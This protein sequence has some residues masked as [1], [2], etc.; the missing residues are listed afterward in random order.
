MKSN[1][2]RQGRTARITVAVVV[3][4]AMVMST[5]LSGAAF[6]TGPDLGKTL[7]NPTEVY[8]KDYPADVDAS[9]QAL[10]D[11]SVG[12]APTGEEAVTQSGDAQANGY[13]TFPSFNPGPTLAASDAANAAQLSTTHAGS[14]ITVNFAGKNQ[15]Q[16]FATCDLVDSDTV[17]GNPANTPSLGAIAYIPTDY[18]DSF[19]HTQGYYSYYNY[20]SPYTN[21]YTFDGPPFSYT[22]SFTKAGPLWVKIYYQKWTVKANMIT[23]GAI[24]IVDPAQ[25]RKWE[26]DMTTR[27]FK[28]FNYDLLGV[29]NYYEYERGKTFKTAWV[30]SGTVYPKVTP[31]RSGFKFGGWYTNWP[32]GSKVSVGSAKVSFGSGYSK[33]LYVHWKRTIKFVF[34]PNKGKITKGKTSFKLAYLKKTPKAPTASRSGYYPLGWYHKKGSNYAFYKKG[35]INNMS[36]SPAK[37]SQQWIKNGKKKTVSRSELKTILKAWK[38]FYVVRKAAKAAIGGGGELIATGTYNGYAASKYEWEGTTSA[39]YVQII[40]YTGGYR[41]N[42]IAQITTYGNE[43]SDLRK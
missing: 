11:A 14:N 25:P 29:I 6:A 13:F 41:F 38:K 36:T 40:F 17:A 9:A 20:G 19:G 22:G 10:L 32:K 42:D 37:F 30:K 28:Q 2:K 18:Q 15:A 34:N 3:S 33:T 5:A 26:A 23:S 31:K 27:Y 16:F 35:L 21:D 12:V 39:A 1:R 7:G 43:Y 4:L 24:Q 8:T